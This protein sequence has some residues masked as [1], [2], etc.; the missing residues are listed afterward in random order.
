MIS[1]VSSREF[2]SPDSIVRKNELEESLVVLS[3]AIQ[4]SNEN[5]A[6]LRNECTENERSL[7]ALH[8]DSSVVSKSVE[9]EFILLQK[10]VNDQQISQCDVVSIQQTLNDTKSPSSDGTLIWKITDVKQKI[11]K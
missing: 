9:E 3:T 6:R 11:G 10:L 7:K 2:R 8:Q 1:A 4:Q 5:Q